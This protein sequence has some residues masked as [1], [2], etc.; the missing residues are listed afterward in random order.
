[1][2]RATRSAEQIQRLVHERVHKIEEVQED[3]AKIGVPLPTR[4]EVDETG[5]NWDMSVFGNASGY[6]EG[7]RRV[8]EETRA[9]VNL[10]SEE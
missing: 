4:H 8:V 1:M 10:P 3:K 2:A 7:I 6:V 5:C 9:K